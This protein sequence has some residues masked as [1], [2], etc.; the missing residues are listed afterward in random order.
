[1]LLFLSNMQADTL[2]NVYIFLLNLFEVVDYLFKVFYTL[3]PV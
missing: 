3:K 1:M 2:K